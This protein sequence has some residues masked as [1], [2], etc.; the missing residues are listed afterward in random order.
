MAYKGAAWFIQQGAAWLTR[1]QRNSGFGVAQQ[2]VAW[3][4]RAR[5]D[6]VGYGVVRY[7]SVWLGRVRF[8]SVVAQ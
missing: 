1:V 5:L 8:N 6:P 4:I 3:L 2:V 7:S